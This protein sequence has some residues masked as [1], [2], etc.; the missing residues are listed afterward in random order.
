MS[1]RS[2]IKGLQPGFIYAIVIESVSGRATVRL[3]TGT[4]LHHIAVIGGPVVPGQQ[5]KVQW[6]DGI[7]Q[8][9]APGSGIGD[10]YLGSLALG[11]G[12]GSGGIPVVGSGCNPHLIW[13]IRDAETVEYERSAAGLGAANASALLGDFIIIPKGEIA[14][15][16]TLTAGVRYI[17]RSQTGSI[18]SGRIALVDGAT[19]ESLSVIRT[20]NTHCLA[21]PTSGF[22]FLYNCI[23]E[24]TNTLGD[25]YVMHY[26]GNPTVIFK[27][28]KL[29]GIS[30]AGEGHT[31]L[32]EQTSQDRDGEIF[33]DDTTLFASTD[34]YKVM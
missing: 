33:L 4:H 11:S 30:T 18:L 12:G 25:A 24:V 32:V 8:V 19:L 34:Y 10:E 20:D 29:Y 27:D 17:G 21:T 2:T 31:I 1:L 22:V 26:T 23:F 3:N 28:C 9:V 5:V 15:N 13:L 6:Q 7:P 16:H 14:G